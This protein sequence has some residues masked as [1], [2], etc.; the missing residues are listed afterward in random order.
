M[1]WVRRYRGEIGPDGSTVSSD[2]FYYEPV[3]R[4]MARFATVSPP[5]RS[6]QERVQVSKF[7]FLT[8]GL[9]DTVDYAA[10]IH[11]CKGWPRC[12]RAGH[13]YQRTDSVACPVRW[14]AMLEMCLNHKLRE[15]VVDRPTDVETKGTVPP[16]RRHTATA[17][18]GAALWCF[19]D[20]VEGVCGPLTCSFVP[21][22]LRCHFLIRCLQGCLLHTA[23][24]MAVAYCP[25]VVH[26]CCILPSVGT[27]LLHTALW[28]YMAVAYCPLVVHGCCILPSVGAWMLHT[29]LC[30][31]MAVAYC[32]LVVHT[33][34]LCDRADHTARCPLPGVG[35]CATTPR[36]SMA[37]RPSTA[38][39]RTGP[40]KPRG[41][42]TF[43][44]WT[45]LS[46]VAVQPEQR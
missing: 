8:D 34:L 36:G 23:L 37:S 44:H 4:N 43:E 27:W 13:T 35:R 6:I 26:G 45:L 24:Y 3:D 42:V 12:P 7:N 16:L 18:A 29:A 30:W 9:F 15:W 41:A 20:G 14:G 19:V 33:T 46:S 28:W 31:D 5:R 10:W 38:W 32:P 39:N 25:L 40:A 2:G 1:V 11:F 22:P 21:S 17:P